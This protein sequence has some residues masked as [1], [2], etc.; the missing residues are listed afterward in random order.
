Y[1]WQERFEGNAAHAKDWL[2]R[3]APIDRW[4]EPNAAY[5]LLTTAP[6][7]ARFVAA[8]LAG[9]GLSPATWQALLT[10]V[11]ETSPGTAMALGVRVENGPDGRIFYHSGNNGRR[12]TCYMTGDV[13][14]GTG[15]DYFTNASNGTSLVE[16]LSG[17]CSPAA[18]SRHRAEYDRFDAPRLVAIRSI[19]Q[20]AVQVGTD[21]ARA[22]L[23]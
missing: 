2:W 15:F 7:Y 9:R 16:A 10:P 18:H 8:V 5:T 3:V 6:D 17:V 23:R 13:G 21:S 20:A 11:S 14:R 19:Q 22:Q 1:V 12:F 4:V